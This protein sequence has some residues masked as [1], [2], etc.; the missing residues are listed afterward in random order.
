MGALPCGRLPSSRGMLAALLWAL[1]VV[2]GPEF[3]NLTPDD[4]LD[5]GL[6]EVGPGPAS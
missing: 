2:R 1:P 3:L 4:H 5:A 6:D